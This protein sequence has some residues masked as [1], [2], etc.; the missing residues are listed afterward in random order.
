[1]TDIDRLKKDIVF[2]ATLRG[3]ALTF[4]STWGLFSPRG[5]DAGTRLLVERIDVGAADTTLD[6]GCGYG[7]IGIAVARS[8][9]AGTVHMTDKDVVAVA[10]AR[11]NVEANG[12]GNCQVYLSNAFDAVPDVAFDQVLANLP[13]NVGAEML[14]IILRD[15]KA[16]LR[17]GG[18]LCVVTVNG[19]RKF[20]RRNF[21]ETFGNYTKVKQGPHHTVAQA[22]RDG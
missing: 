8:C 9:P 7:A 13:A 4:H 21:E 12:L 14:T 18:R 17:P 20:I 16:R 5:I 19:L 6:L 1:M 11:K 3:E 22:V 15:A 10:Y 2:G